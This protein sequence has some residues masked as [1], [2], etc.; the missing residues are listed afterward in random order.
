MARIRVLLA[1]DH[2][3]LRDS[4]KAFFELHPEIEVVGE[5]ADGVQAIAGA[6]RLQPDVL[7]LDISM[8]GLTGLEVIRRLKRDLPHCKILVLSQHQAPDFVLPILKA[9]AEGYLLKKAGGNE[10]IRAIKAVY[11]NEAYLH[12]AIAQVVLDIRVRDETGQ[13]DTLAGLSDRERE[14][15]ILIGAGHTNQEISDALSISKKT[16]DKHRANLMK[17]LN[18]PSRAALIRLAVDH[19]LGGPEA[20]SR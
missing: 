13:E 2:A 9:G 14:V 8:P 1:D 12:P 19:G 15:L 5:A 11:Q 10:V 20:A 4:L 17:K 18:V 6:L 16:V 7:L 3:I